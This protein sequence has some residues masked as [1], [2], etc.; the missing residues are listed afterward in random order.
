[1]PSEEEEEEE[2]EE[3]VVEEKQE[4]ARPR[5]RRPATKRHRVVVSV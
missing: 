1:M 4:R 3:E 5:T 2:E